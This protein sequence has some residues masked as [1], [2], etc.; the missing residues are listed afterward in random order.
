MTGGLSRLIDGEL[1]LIE[2]VALVRATVP[3]RARW[4]RSRGFWQ[5]LRGLST[6]ALF[7]W[8]SGDKLV[9]SAFAHHVTEAVPAAESLI[10]P[11]C[12]HVPQFE[13]PE[14]TMA[15]TRNFL[16]PG[17]HPRSAADVLASLE[18]TTP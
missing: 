1:P 12:G 2:W 3:P 10:I 11:R 13:L 15:L 6:P 4:Q 14:L 17:R 16:H 18:E 8:G 9:P 7:L 5:R